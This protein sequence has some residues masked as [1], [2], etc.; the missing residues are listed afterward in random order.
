MASGGAAQAAA[1][2]TPSCGCSK[3]LVV[4]V[5]EYLMQERAAANIS[6]FCRDGDTR[7]GA[8]HLGL[9]GSIKVH[10]RRNN[11]WLEAKKQSF[12]YTYGREEI[13]TGAF[14]S[15]YDIATKVFGN[16]KKHLDACGL[17]PR[18]PT[19]KCWSEAK[20]YHDS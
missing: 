11:P 15:I 6:Q 8:H 13:C 20:A 17:V 12:Q 1:N 10:Q 9:A 5:S 7:K 16:L 18:T 19:W 3:T 4:T 14:H 2:A